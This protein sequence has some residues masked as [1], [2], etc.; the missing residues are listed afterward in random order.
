[1][2]R[3]PRQ[4]R[5]T[6][7]HVALMQGLVPADDGTPPAPPPGTLKMTDEDFA[8]VAKLLREAHAG[9]RDRTRNET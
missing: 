1:M 2:V 4:M 7:E 5:L 3:S 6:A 9:D 8:A